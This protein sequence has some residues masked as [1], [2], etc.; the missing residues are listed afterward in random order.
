[1]PLDNPDWTPRQNVLTKADLDELAKLLAQHPCKFGQIT[2]EQMDKMA[3]LSDFFDRA[4]KKIMDSITYAVLAILGG[5]LWMLYNH[6]FFIGKK[7]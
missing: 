4:E 3:R 5:L 1:M 6:G 7:G 2:H